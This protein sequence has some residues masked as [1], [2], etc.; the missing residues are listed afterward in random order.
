MSYQLQS[1]SSNLIIKTHN[2]LAASTHASREI[3]HHRLGHHSLKKLNKLASKS[4]IS[5][6]SSLNNSFCNGCG[7]SKNSKLPFTSVPCHTSHPL[8]LLHTDVWGPAFITFVNQFRYYVIFADDFTK[9]CWFYPLQS[10]SNVFPTFVKFKNLVENLLLTKIVA[11]KSDFGGEYLSTQFSNFIVANGISHQLSCPHTPQQNSCV[12]RKHRHIVETTGT[13]LTVSKVPH[14][15]W[16]HAFSTAVFL[17]N[18]LP[19]ASQLSS[20][21]R[22]FHR[23]LT[24][25]TLKVFGCSCFP[26]LQSYSSSKLDPKSKHCVFLGYSLNHKGYKCLDPTTNKIYISRNIIFD[27]GSFP[28]HNTATSQ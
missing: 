18:R 28:F 13:L 6:S 14:G 15:Y 24:Y 27:E 7:L 9:Y 21:E 2:A 5:M 26:W 10:K 8:E 20:W 23:S 19:T 16:D 25:G 12:E 1:Q 3:W 11:L 17:I 4:C 22:L